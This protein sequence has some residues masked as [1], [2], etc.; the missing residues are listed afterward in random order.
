MSVLRKIPVSNHYAFSSVFTH[1]LE[2]TREFIS[3]L[4]GKP[5]SKV[6]IA[7]REKVMEEVFAGK[8]I[9][10]DVYLKDAEGESFDLEL[11][12]SDE[13]N[14]EKRVRYYQSILTADA[15]SKGERY[16][17][18]KD[19]YVIFI[20]VGND[21][22]GLG[23]TVYEIEN[24]IVSAS[25]RLFKDGMHSYIF[26]FS[27]VREAS[28]DQVIEEMANYFYNDDVTGRLSER[29]DE[30]VRELNEN[31][32]WR[33]KVMTWEQEKEALAEIYFEKGKTRGINEGLA[34]GKTEI[35][36]AMLRKGFDVSVVKELTG[37]DEGDI[38]KLS[39]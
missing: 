6:V 5:I 19:S 18:L 25:N 12:I 8:G 9:R 28:N 23:K 13:R 16:R 36:L 39:N 7:D 34:Q 20:C 22:I 35:A 3:A 21:P 1:D 30:I 10:F 17:D 32:T 11:Q 24:T 2:V 37:L 33:E 31:V 27:P 26:N 14:I 29:I 15:L 4:I 38:R